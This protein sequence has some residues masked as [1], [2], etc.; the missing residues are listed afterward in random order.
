MSPTSSLPLLFILEEHAAT[1]CLNYYCSFLYPELYSYTEGPEFVL[2]RKCF[3]EDFRTHGMC[4]KIIILHHLGIS[5]IVNNYCASIDHM[6][7]ISVYCQLVSDKK[8][9]ELD[10]AHHRAHAMRLLDGLEVIAREK[11]LKVARAILYMAQGW[12]SS[13]TVSN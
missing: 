13:L 12:S 2:N 8:W 1:V 10:A 5:L 9:T 7:C 11:R 4:F 6:F 3:E